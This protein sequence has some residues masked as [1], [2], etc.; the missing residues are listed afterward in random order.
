[1]IVF[2]KGV[3]LDLEPHQDRRSVL[4]EQMEGQGRAREL[5]LNG[6]GVGRARGSRR[7]KRDWWELYRR[8]ELSGSKQAATCYSDLAAS[9][10]KSS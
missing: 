4:L 6:T 8:E 1:M 9:Q 5:P 3:V 2:A 10:F 7:C